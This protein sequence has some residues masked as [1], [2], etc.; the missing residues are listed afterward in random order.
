ML[1]CIGD[2]QGYQQEQKQEHS[3]YGRISENELPGCC[4]RIV[5]EIE[6]ERGVRIVSQTERERERERETDRQTETETETETERDRDRDRETERQREENRK[7]KQ[8]NSK[9]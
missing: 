3:P 4:V 1:T 5:R 9:Y 7:K 6:I 8:N 2:T